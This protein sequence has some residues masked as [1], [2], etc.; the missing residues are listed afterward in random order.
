MK[1]RRTLVAGVLATV[2]LSGCGAAEKLSPQVAVRD[3]ANT[4]VKAEQGT[5]TFSVVGSEDDLN[6]VLN[7]GAA[8][9]DKDRLGLRLLGQSHVSLMTAADMF[10]L[11]VK[12]G[13]IDHAVELRY[14]G[15]KLYARADVPAIAKLMGASPDE[16]NQTVQSLAD[17]RF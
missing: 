7:Q 14:V 16:V 6:A 1:L 12:V 17:Q 11:D 9:S 15:K 5:F 2:V 10:A 8:L 3:A 13:D 4:T